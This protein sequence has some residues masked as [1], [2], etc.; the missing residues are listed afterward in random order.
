MDVVKLEKS[1]FKMILSRRSIFSETETSETFLYQIVSQL[2]TEK[3]I[4]RHQRLIWLN[5]LELDIFIPALQLGVEY[6]GQQH[7]HPIEAWGG[8][9][10]IKALQERDARKVQ[11][12]VERGVTL[13]T[14]DYMEPLTA[15]YLRVY[16]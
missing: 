6:Q 4:L 14:I 8:E 11:I 13:I 5:G 2:F 10:A 15:E 3:E 16:Y 1:L 7:F 12:C 9:K